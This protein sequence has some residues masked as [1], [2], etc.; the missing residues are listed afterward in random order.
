LHLLL[1]LLKLL[2]G[3]H[4]RGWILLVP[5]LVLGVLLRLGGSLLHLLLLQLMLL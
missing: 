1:L 5:G 4:A 3:S 2:H